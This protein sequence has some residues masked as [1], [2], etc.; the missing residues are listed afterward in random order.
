MW[1][2][3]FP[4]ARGLG[5]PGSATAFLPIPGLGPW[6]WDWSCQA[7]AHDYVMKGRLARLIPAIEREI[8]EAEERK[9]HRQ[10]QN[11]LFQAQ[12]IEAIGQ[13]AGGV[14]H[15][16][17]NLLT[18]INGY[19]ELLLKDTTLD[20]LHK[21]FLEAIL[22]AGDH[23]AALTRQLLAFSRRQVLTPQTLNLNRV[24]EG[25]HS[26]IRRLIGEDVDLVC[27][28]AKDLGSVRVDPGQMEQIVLNMVVNS[29]DAMPRGG[30]ITIETM[31]VMLDETYVRTH[32]SVSPGPHVMLAVS[33]TGIGMGAET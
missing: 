3:C 5:T 2:Y 13:L 28:T 16:F 1:K 25:V 27:H 12:K 31:N 17:N 7:G 11:Q 4:R 6:G 20:N 33:N 14:A 32:P 24:L 10:T 19:T 15:D 8:R 9:Q 22:K 29:R 18:V 26:M 21:P 30:K 23:A